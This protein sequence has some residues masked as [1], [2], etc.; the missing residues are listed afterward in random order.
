MSRVICGLEWFHPPTRVVRATVA[1][2]TATRT[3]AWRALSQRLRELLAPDAVSRFVGGTHTR[4][5]ADNL[6]PGLSQAQIAVV[7]RQL[8]LGSGSELKATSTGKRPAHAP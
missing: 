4:R 2:V 6:L 3:R 8:S 1:G 7:R 5:F